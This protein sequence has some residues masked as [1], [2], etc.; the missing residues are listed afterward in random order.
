MKSKLSLYTIYT[1]DAEKIVRRVTFLFKEGYYFRKRPYDSCI[2]DLRH[3][4]NV[5]N[6]HQNSEENVEKK[7]DND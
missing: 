2:L 4:T 3:E 5:K 1:T 6:I 7:E